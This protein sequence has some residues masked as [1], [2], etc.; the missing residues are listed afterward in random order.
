MI[1]NI[2][3]NTQGTLCAHYIDIELTN[4]DSSMMWFSSCVYCAIV[5]NDV[6]YMSWG[7]PV[8][9]QVKYLL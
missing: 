3:S 5:G 4:V 6:C 7:L 8:A 2:V 9:Q 1:Y